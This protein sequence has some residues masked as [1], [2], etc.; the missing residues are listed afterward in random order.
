MSRALGA[1]ALAAVLGAATASGQTAPGP[2]ADT[3]RALP[4]VEVTASPFTLVPARAPLAGVW[5]A[6]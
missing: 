4:A 2:P 3:T 5:R 1:V 6:A